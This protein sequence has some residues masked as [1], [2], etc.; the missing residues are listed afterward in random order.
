[1]TRV[2]FTGTR[3]GLTSAQRDALREVL[4]ALAPSVVAHGD[5]VGGD[6][7]AH[8]VARGLGIAVELHPPSIA[9]L[10][11]WCAMREGEVVCDPLPYL[12]RNC[13]LVDATEVLVA[14]PREEHGETLRSGTWACARYARRRNRLVV[15]VRPSGRVEDSDGR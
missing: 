5:C 12:T 8:A 13:A 9:A 6:A 14:C 1:M 2:G 3:E 7:T 10:R 4:R 15:V 11:A